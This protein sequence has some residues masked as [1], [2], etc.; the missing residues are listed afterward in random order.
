[1]ALERAM[2]QQAHEVR[3]AEEAAKQPK[4]EM[5]GLRIVPSA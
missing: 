2:K 1:V 4:D 5:P 3:V